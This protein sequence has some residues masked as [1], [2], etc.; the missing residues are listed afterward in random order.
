MRAVVFDLSV[1]KYAVAKALGKQFPSLYY[2]KP[3]C[4]SFRDV[5]EPALRGPEWAKIAVESCGF[6]GSDLSLIF[7]KQ[8]P[9]MSP[10]GSFPCVLGHEI[11]G[12][13]VEV[14]AEAK[15]RGWKEGDRVAV[16]PA[17]GCAIRGISP[18]CAACASGHPATCFHAGAK[19]GN[20]APGFSI[21][22][23]KDLPGGFAEKLIAHVSQLHRVKD[24]T[25]DVRAVLTEPLAIA[26]HAVLKRE[27]KPDEHILIIGGGII[28]Y[29]VLA[30]LRLLGHENRI[31]QLL[32]LDFQAQLARELG[33]DDVIQPGPNVD[34][35]DEVC[36]R[37]GARRW[38]PILG[39]DVLTGG[40]DVTY[41][42]IGAPESVRDALAYTRSQGTIVQVGAAGIMKLD[43]TPTW[44]RELSVIGTFYYGPEAARAN[45]HTM[46]VVAEL[47]ADPRAARLD[48]LVTHTFPL[49][50]YQEAV[51]ANV[52]RGRYKSVKT[53]FRP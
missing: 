16:N 26:T 31:T 53:V 11:F 42:C 36:R 4:L 29:A 6:C 17:F 34:V 9:S 18:P 48:A 14:G 2:G 3:S 30:A 12:K 5:P 46:D 33:A 10:F 19:D 8:S 35:L 44:T 39:R 45:R 51:I 50:R 27:P 32:L 21:G 28:A 37:T 41:D 24:A 47:L 22:Y 38:K 40:F 13:L 25:P 43:L 23:H 15:A 20:L 1:A 49:E 52:Q 7:L